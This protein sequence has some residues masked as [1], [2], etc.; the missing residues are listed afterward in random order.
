MKDVGYPPLYAGRDWA[1]WDFSGPPTAAGNNSNA[2][3]N[4]KG[5]GLLGYCEPSDA[6]ALNR[7]HH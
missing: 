3:L 7:T 5:R 4:C 2:E 6:G 1:L